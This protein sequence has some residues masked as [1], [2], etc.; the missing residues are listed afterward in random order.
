[1]NAKKETIFDAHGIK[2]KPTYSIISNEPAHIFSCPRT[3]EEV[4]SIGIK[5][6]YLIGD[7]Y[8]K[9][10]D[11]CNK[12]SKEKLKM[13]ALRQLDKKTE[14]QRLANI[15]LNEKL[16]YFY[17]NG[18]QVIE[19]PVSEKRAKEINGFFNR[20][21]GNYLIKIE[22]LISQAH[23]SDEKINELDSDVSKIEV[24]MLTDLA[25]LYY[26]Q[27]IRMAFKEIIFL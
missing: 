21:A 16:T 4:Y 8:L 22:E 2:D 17:N 3:T 6:Q 14:I 18:G 19:P 13:M 15:D 11:K 24:R 9:Y 26:E 23:E 5:L 27:E 20:I 10:A 12:A 1:M 7:L 25:N